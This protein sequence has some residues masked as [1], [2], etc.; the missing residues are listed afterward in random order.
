MTDNASTAPLLEVRNL[1]VQFTTRGG[2]V[3]VLDDISF[4]LERGERISFVGESGCGK[5]MT[6]LALMGLLPAMGRVSGGQ[7]LFKGEDLTTASP[8]RLRRLRGNEV[9]MIFQEPMTSLNPVF[10]IGQQI[11]EV[12]RLHRG[13]DNAEARSRSIELLQAVRIPDAA[14]RVDDYPHQLSG[15]QRQRVMIAIALAC[16]PEILIAD[17]PTTA[18]DV[19]V[20]AEIFALLRDLGAKLDTAIILITHD[21][22]AV[23][24]MSER[25]LVM[26]AGRRVEEGQVADVIKAPAHPYTRGLIACVPHITSD[27]GALVDTLPEIDGIVPPITR[28]GRDECLFAPRCARAADTCWSAKPQQSDISGHSGHSVSCWH[29][30]GAEESR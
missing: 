26:Y 23:A 24:Q 17:E 21:M 25:M 16:E 14:A 28:F 9:S 12:L 11:S 5:S 27:V 19:T 18:L 1:S 7:V 2:T 15:G 13:I 30:F 6:A 8:A 29:P 20:Q 10:T 22:G 4:T 3:T